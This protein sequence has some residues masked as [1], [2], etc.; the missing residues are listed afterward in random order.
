MSHRSACPHPTITTMT[1]LLR[2]L[3]ITTAI[4]CA[5]MAGAVHAAGLQV[6]NVLVELE[7][8]DNAQGLWLVNSG[9]RPIRAQSRIMQWTQSDNANQ[10]DATRALTASPPIVE[11]APGQQQFV[12]VVRLQKGAADAEQSYRLLVNELPQPAT[13]T[14]AGAGTGSA[15]QGVQLLIEHSIPVFVIPQNGKRLGNLRG[16]TDLAGLNAKLV[17]DTTGGTDSTDAAVQLQVR[18][19][20][21]QRVRITRV[22]FVNTQGQRTA[23]VPGL[24][25]YVLA[26]QVM[27]WKLPLPAT[28]LQSGGQLQVRI[29]DDEQPQTLLQIPARQ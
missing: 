26:G 2:K 11:I 18:N 14:E 16:A 3:L 28:E 24:L 13:R 21:P 27:Q 17:P 22:E 10:L 29:N 6:S 7:Q 19:S 4:A 15:G 20:A 9:D 8:Q 1:P 5:S 23:L 12:R 25:G